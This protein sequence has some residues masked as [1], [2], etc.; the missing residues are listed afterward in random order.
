MYNNKNITKY[1]V[2]LYPLRRGYYRTHKIVHP[3][4]IKINIMPKI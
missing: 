4:F 1:A 3:Q 2:G